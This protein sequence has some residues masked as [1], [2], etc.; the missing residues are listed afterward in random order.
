MSQKVV[1]DIQQLEIKSKGSDAVNQATSKQRPGNT[2]A[3]T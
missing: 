2:Q 1:L 3:N